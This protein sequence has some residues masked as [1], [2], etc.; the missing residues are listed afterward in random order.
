LIGSLLTTRQSFLIDEN[1]CLLA[2]IINQLLWKVEKHYITK[3][4]TFLS[5][6]VLL[7]I[8]IAIC[9]TYITKISAH[10]RLSSST[11]LQAFS[12]LLTLSSF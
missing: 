1:S 5:L 10:L 7:L 2:V 4:E 9:V 12:N 6:L 8:F 3:K 11:V